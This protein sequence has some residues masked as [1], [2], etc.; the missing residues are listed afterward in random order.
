MTRDK[1]IDAILAEMRSDDE[2]PYDA[3][4]GDTTL[5]DYADRIEAAMKRGHLRDFAKK[6][7]NA[8][9]LRDALVKI[10]DCTTEICRGVNRGRATEVM[11][12]NGKIATIADSALAAPARNCD[13]CATA[14][15]AL[16]AF[17][18]EK[19]IK[20]EDVDALNLR[21]FFNWLFAPAE[22]EIKP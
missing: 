14:K 3:K 18:R 4:V 22:G 11:A 7:G 20:S 10:V 21:D 12:Y 1:E 13:R 2:H 17:I 16:D 19:E 15:D 9:A 8:A 5:K 6:V